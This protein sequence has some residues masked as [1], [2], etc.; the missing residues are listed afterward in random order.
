MAKLF[1]SPPTQQ[2]HDNFLETN[3][4]FV[5]PIRSHTVSLCCT[6]NVLP[7]QWNDGCWH[8]QKRVNASMTTKK[9]SPN[10]WKRSKTRRSL[11]LN[12]TSHR[13]KWKRYLKLLYLFC[14]S[15]SRSGHSFSRY[16]PPKTGE[17]HFYLSQYFNFVHHSWWSSVKF[18]QCCSLYPL[19][20]GNKFRFHC[21]SFLQNPFSFY[22]KA[23]Q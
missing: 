6:L 10:D 3:T 1:I 18:P 17:L 19:R 22:E 14:R 5:S 7:K 9:R 15:R 13:I 23:E 16:G 12:T 20:L 21:D 8:E 4:I 11:S 2:N